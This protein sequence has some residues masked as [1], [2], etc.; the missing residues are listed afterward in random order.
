VFPGRPEF[1]AE[2]A[3]GHN[4]VGL[5]L[6]DKG[7]LEGAEAAQAEALAIQKRLAAEF[8]EITDYRNAVAGTLFNLANLAGRRR[9]FAAARRF[10]DE[11]FPHHQAAL[12]GNPQRSD[13]RQFYRDSQLELTRTYAG[14]GDRPEA[15]AVATKWHNLGWDPAVDAYGAACMLAQCMPIVENDDKLAAARRQAEIAFY[16]DQAIAML[17]D[18]LAKGYND[19]DHL[20]TDKDL[21]PLRSRED[22]KTMVAELE[23]KVKKN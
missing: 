11:A 2:L 6:R 21:D 10:L 23:A 18:A 17:R 3:T 9:D 16:A 7:L 15:L 20:Q 19:A 5:L 22:F 12:Q 8:P 1:R 14:Q 4:A 13:Y